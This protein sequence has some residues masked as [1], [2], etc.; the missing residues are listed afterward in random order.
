MAALTSTIIA[1]VGVVSSGIQAYQGYQKQ[2]EVDKAASKAVSDAMKI[3]EQNLMQGVQ[4]PMEGY[5]YEKQMIQQQ[6]SQQL[7]QLSG[8]GMEALL[9]GV[10]QVSQAQAQSAQNLGARVSQ[11]IYKNELMQAQQ[12]QEIESN[13]VNRELAIRQAQLYGAQAASAEGSQQLQQGVTGVIGGLAAGA[14]GYLKSRPLYS[15][16]GGSNSLS[17]GL[18]FDAGLQT[19][20]VA[21]TRINWNTGKPII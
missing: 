6:G 14:A 13:R 1:G 19:P 8:A 4:V 20:D 12:A 7:Q 5:D 18:G 9:G 16:L 21:N 15:G 2:K 17:S 11:D 3:K 10:G